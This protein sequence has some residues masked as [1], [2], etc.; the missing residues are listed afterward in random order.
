MD[1]SPN[2]KAKDS[3]K[4]VPKIQKLP[5][6]REVSPPK[7]IEKFDES[8]IQQSNKKVNNLDLSNLGSLDGLNDA[9]KPKSRDS[10]LDKN[11]VS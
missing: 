10:S 8:S 6:K 5:P 4:P 11:Y 3:P 2:L 9:L 7:K 1:D